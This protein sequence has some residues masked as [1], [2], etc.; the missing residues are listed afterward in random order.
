MIL[1][2]SLFV[3]VIGNFVKISF[4]IFIHFKSL[5][6]R[7]LGKNQNLKKKE[8]E[9]ARKRKKERKNLGL[10][11]YLQPP[12]LYYDLKYI[13]TLSWAFDNSFDLI[14][15][16]PHTHF[17]ATSNHRN[18]HLIRIDTQSVLFY[19]NPFSVTEKNPTFF[20]F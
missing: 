2:W 5:N 7:Y 8:K 17:S 1:Y 9:K 6:I 14:I 11:I 19:P 18:I 20:L 3:D 4:P 10:G 12:F 15:I 13:K 16:F